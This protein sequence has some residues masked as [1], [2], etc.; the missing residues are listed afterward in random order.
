M[1]R[2]AIILLGPPG[3]GKGT[4][5]RRLGEHFRYARISTGDMLREAVKNNSKLGEEA[6]RFIEAGDLVPDALVDEIVKDRLGRED[7]ERGFVLD[8]YPRTIPQARFLETLFDGEDV[9]TVAVGI[10][11][12]NEVLLARLA[13]RWTC[14]TCGMIYNLASN[15]PRME[16][17]CNGCDTTLVHRQDD[18]AIVVQERLE[19]YQHLTR[20]LV[21]YYQ[22]RGCYHEISGERSME[23]IYEELKARVAQSAEGDR[24]AGAP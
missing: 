21:Q 23:D 13:G 9:R 1:S 8:G 2:T 19:V 12:R 11:V 17:H 14:P 15:R 4:Q 10:S 16:G 5:A 24:Q 3:A 6:R 22:A 18:S 20:P 7:C